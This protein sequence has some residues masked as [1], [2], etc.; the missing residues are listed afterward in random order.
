[1]DLLK[2]AM[3]PSAIEQLQ[4]PP[5]VEL[6]EWKDKTA[7]IHRLR[8]GVLAT[9]AISLYNLSSKLT[10]KNVNASQPAIELIPV[11]MTLFLIGLLIHRISSLPKHRPIH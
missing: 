1:M 2:L 4:R 5:H 7:T 10:C 9:S 3:Y 6:A 11:F 8:A